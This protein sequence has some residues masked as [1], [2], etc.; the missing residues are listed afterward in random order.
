[1]RGKVHAD[2]LVLEGILGVHL[3]APLGDERVAEERGRPRSHE[4]SMGEKGWVTIESSESL[5]WRRGRAAVCGERVE[6]RAG[7]SPG[8]CGERDGRAG[9]PSGFGGT[10]GWRVCRAVGSDVVSVIFWFCDSWQNAMRF[11]QATVTTNTTTMGGKGS[12]PSSPAGS[13]TKAVPPRAHAPDPVPVAPPTP[14]RESPAPAKPAP[15][16]APKA[17]PRWAEVSARYARIF[18][19]LDALEKRALPTPTDNPREPAS[20]S[21]RDDTCDAARHI[22]DDL[23]GTRGAPAGCATFMRVPSCYYDE[24]LEF[25]RECVGGA[26]VDHMCKTIVMENTKCVNDD[27]ADR[28]NSRWYLVVVQ[29]TAKL[30]QQK[31]QKY[32]H[33]LNNRDGRKCGKKNFH[34][35]L[36]KEEDSERLT[37]YVKGAVCPFG[38][39]DAKMPVI[40]S[41]KITRLAPDTF[42]LG[43]GE[44]DLKI[45]MSA[46]HFVDAAKPYVADITY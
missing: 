46:A 21:R 30:N 33:E 29:Y 40:F 5:A 1:M 12:K 23:V 28:A 7:D 37:G 39:V 43:A 10:V 6:G 22:L 24:P 45:G 18:D 3:G 2:D 35:R 19:R 11:G 36:A 15:A 34:M 8:E 17:D 32:L 27:T 41:D 4:R 44:V 14:T 9:G 26:S 42:W 38:C 13:P 16:A 20:N 31:L 25:R